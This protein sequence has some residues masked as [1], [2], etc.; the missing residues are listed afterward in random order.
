[1]PLVENSIRYALAYAVSQLSTTWL[2]ATVGAEV[3]LDPL[4]VGAALDQ[5][6]PVLPSMASVAGV[7]T[8]SWLEAVTGL[9][10]E[11][12]VGSGVGPG[13]GDQQQK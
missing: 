4:R 3:D 9:P 6:V 1:M 2:T 12:R 13:A 7:P 10:C 8:F 5:R 11:S